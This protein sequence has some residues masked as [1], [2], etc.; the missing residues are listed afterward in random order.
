MQDLSDQEFFILQGMCNMFPD[1]RND[2]MN[3][4]LRDKKEM[5]TAV[6]KAFN[7]LLDTVPHR[8]RVLRDMKRAADKKNS[9][10]RKYTSRSREY[11]RD[12]TDYVD[13]TREDVSSDET[14]EPVI[15]QAVIE[16]SMC[17]DLTTIHTQDE[18]IPF[19][20][21]NCP[22]GGACRRGF[23]YFHTRASCD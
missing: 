4:S 19:I 8:N 1:S 5:T 12:I 16:N 3:A 2:I 14:L 6:L 21:Q 10:Q 22:G 20:E 9:I 18:P 23:T 11:N 7:D 13:L 15:T 17:P